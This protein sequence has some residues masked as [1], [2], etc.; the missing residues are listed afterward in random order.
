MGGIRLGGN[1]VAPLPDCAYVVFESDP[2]DP[3][4]YFVIRL[5]VAGHAYAENY[6][7]TQDVFSFGKQYSDPTL[8]P[9]RAWVVFGTVPQGGFFNTVEVMPIDGSALVT[10]ASYSNGSGGSG[11]QTGMQPSWHPDSDTVIYAESVAPGDT[12]QFIRTVQKDGTGDTGLISH[13]RSVNG[14]VMFPMFNFDGSRI[15]WYGDGPNPEKLYTALADG[16]GVTNFATRTPAQE[17]PISWANTQDVMVWFDNGVYKTANGDGSGITTI[18]T[19]PHPWWGNTRFAWLPDDSGIV[20]LRKV[21]T[22]PDPKYVLT[23]IDPGGGGITD[24]SPERRSI[25]WRQE[26]DLPRVLN[27]RIWWLRHP[28]DYATTATDDSK[29]VSIL[30]DG[31]DYTVEQTIL[32]FNTT[33]DFEQDFSGFDGR[34]FP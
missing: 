14:F 13:N 30:P 32:D 33:S 1:V 11:T 16:T 19:D 8:S 4:S 29:V 25:G 5:Y 17:T 26:S 18:W 24:I 23:V 31:S 9:D 27:G 3:G 21:P 28:D 6:I 7:H 34:E 12:S 15:A 20:V 22:D 10:V 2:T